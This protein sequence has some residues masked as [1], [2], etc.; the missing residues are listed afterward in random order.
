MLH[1]LRKYLITGLVVWVPLVITFFVVKFLVDLMDNS[2]LLLPPAWRPE[3]LFGFKIPGLGVVL[4]AVILLVT[5]LVTANLLGRKLV[6]LWESV[7]QRIPLVRSIY[8]AVK[9]VMETL[10][11]AGGDSF[12]KVLMIEYPRKGIWTLGFQTGV[13]VGEVQ[14]RT[15][16]EVVTVFV[17]TTPN[18]TSGFIILVPRDEV[19]ELDMSVEDGLKFVMSLGVVSPRW[20][21]PNRPPSN[22]EQRRGGF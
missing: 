2:L 19:V 18:P 10:L 15:S 14:S 6:D 3:A 9:Q 22:G 8:S 1:T 21:Y 13:G 12:R 7:L 17:P 20:P 5:G 11:G 4:A 16:K